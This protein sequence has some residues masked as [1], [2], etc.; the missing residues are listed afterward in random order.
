[1]AVNP[2]V[3]PPTASLKPNLAPG[4]KIWVR[5]AAGDRPPG[6]IGAYVRNADGLWLVTANHVIAGNGHFLPTAHPTH[7]V[8]AGQV[9]ISRT[10]VFSA[11]HR[12]G[13][14]ADAAACLIDSAEATRALTVR[15]GTLTLSQSSNP[16]K[17]GTVVTSHK[18]QGRI[19]ATGTFQ[20]NMKK[21]G[22]PNLAEAEFTNSLL[23]EP[24]DTTFAKPGDSG[25]PVYSKDKIIGL[26]TGTTSEGVVV[27]T[28]EAVLAAL[29][30]I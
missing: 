12:Y 15:E 1:M 7:G 20:I 28:I 22:I 14:Q 5:G 11:L 19:K 10:I 4:A 21:A 27:S 29:K 17:P 24:Q 13:N 9:R 30:L 2:A 16:P 8:Y 23:I 6:S 26:I 25:G 18:G 3:P